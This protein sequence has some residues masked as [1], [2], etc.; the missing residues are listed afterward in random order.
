MTLS[1]VPPPNVA[2]GAA[3]PPGPVDAFER[4]VAEL[5]A[6]LVDPIH[7]SLV[8]QLEQGAV[9][10]WVRA[11]RAALQDVL[12]GVRHRRAPTEDDEAADPAL[13][14]AADALAAGLRERLAESVVVG[15]GGIAAEARAGAHQLARR[16]LGRWVDELDAVSRPGDEPVKLAVGLLPPGVTAA[17]MLSRIDHASYGLSF[18][19][20]LKAL[21]DHV[22]LLFARPGTAVWIDAG[23]QVVHEPEDA[24]TP[25][26]LFQDEAAA[27][28]YLAERGPVA[29]AEAAASVD[30][31]RRRYAWVVEALW[32][33]VAGGRGWRDATS[34]EDIVHAGLELGAEACAAR[35]H[36]RAA[37]ADALRDPV[38]QPLLE[39]VALG[40]DNFCAAVSRPGRVTL[41]Q[42]VKPV[43]IRDRLAEYAARRGVSTAVA[44]QLFAIQVIADLE[45]HASHCEPALAPPHASGA[46]ARVLAGAGLGADA[47]ARLRADVRRGAG[48]WLAVPY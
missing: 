37:D 38:A 12:R 41:W 21:R 5:G 8:S 7:A 10:G 25:Y 36:P 13:A 44:S 45:G 48:F 6:R 29:P 43:T 15:A 16:A 18:P 11:T 3:L 47:E 32:H 20:L 27:R 39:A 31:W 34:I 24:C 2:A 1:R 35:A 46:F 42:L 23:L 26:R 22:D 17:R 40:V 30:T 4:R 14:V 19:F 33:T 9:D 28:L